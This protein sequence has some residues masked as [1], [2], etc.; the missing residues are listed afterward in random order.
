MSTIEILS[1]VHIG[2][3]ALVEPVCYKIA[4]GKAERYS[5]IDAMRSAK[6]ETLLDPTV[7]TR[8]TTA[9][10]KQDY[11]ALFLTRNYAGTPL[12]T[13]KWEIAFNPFQ[14]SSRINGSSEIF[15][16]IKALDRPIIPGSSIKGS[17]E[18]ALKYAFLKENI[19]KVKRNADRFLSSKKP[20]AT[21]DLFFLKLV[22]GDD[23]VNENR[24]LYGDFLK[25]LYGA[26]EC[27]DV[28][29]EKMEAC[30]ITRCHYDDSKKDMKLGAAETI[31]PGQTAA[32]SQV[33]R[34]NSD[35]KHFLREIKG[36]GKNRICSELIE[37][38]FNERNLIEA[39]HVYAADMITSESIEGSMEM[40]EDMGDVLTE[41]IRDLK[42]ALK[43][44]GKSRNTAIVRIG[45]Y[46]T[47]F[48]KTV[49]W[50][51]KSQMYDLYE[52]YFDKVFSPAPRGKNKP[53]ANSM[54]ITIPVM[55][56]GDRDWLPGFIRITL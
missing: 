5:M 1:P 42:A 40:F 45:K 29:F 20:N 26:L 7:I 25:D 8:I 50:L 35:K 14:K 46:G 18:C 17:V 33:I 30:Q 21:D 3:G 28:S 22:F 52:D 27:A 49:S 48:Y 4:N 2:T 51:F 44:A 39:L 56:D 38:F 13:M 6:K 11:L 41:Q 24:Q 31:S 19:E 15:E 47:Y 12:Y 16:Q 43:D 53:D 37:W 54:P 10:S 32:V 23:T 34:M 9:S 55:N 36:Y